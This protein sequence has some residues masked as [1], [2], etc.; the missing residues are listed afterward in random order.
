M[1]N[2]LQSFLKYLEIQKQY[3]SH[4]I[5]SYQFDLEEFIN[6]LKTEAIEQFQ[7][8]DYE[9]LRL[10]LSYLYDRQLEPTT[11]SRKLSSLRS[12]Y[13]YLLKEEKIDDNPLHLIHGPKKIKK[14]PDFLFVDEVATLIDGIDTSTPLG[15]RNRAIFELMY[16]SGL[17]ASELVSI[18]LEDL[19]MNTKILKVHGKGSKERYV[20]FH[21]LAKKW[22]LEYLK[23]SRQSLYKHRKKDHS[24]VFVNKNGDPLTTRGLRDLMAREGQQSSLAKA[25][26]P[27]ALRHSFA[28]HMLD[29]GAKLRYVQEM[30]GHENLS[31]TEI[32]THISKE[33]LK[34][35]YHQSH[36]LEIN[37]KND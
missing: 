6:F 8:V 19:D 11:I 15:I 35:V 26:H 17:R 13:D 2:E 3:S 28:T 4:T 9:V 24:Y 25:I 5:E 33:K 37:E 27:H 29:A 10:Y 30:L 32:Y 22:L 18:R 1:N 34:E 7:D 23:V 16:A 36:P 21:N 20:P 14:T 31:T 12:F